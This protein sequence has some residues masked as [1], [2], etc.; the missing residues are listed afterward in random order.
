MPPLCALFGA[1]EHTIEPGAS[2]GLQ[3]GLEVELKATGALDTPKWLIV[4]N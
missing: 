2:V 1:D 4:W 3:A